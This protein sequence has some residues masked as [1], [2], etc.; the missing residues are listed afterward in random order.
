[1][2][3]KKLG[4]KHENLDQEVYRELRS[5]IFEQKLN[6]GTKIYQEKLAQ[7]FGISRTP[8]VNALKKLHQERLITAMP[9]RGF[10]VRHFSAQEIIQAFELREVLEGLAARRA[11][12]GLGRSFK[13]NLL[14]GSFYALVLWGKRRRGQ[15]LQ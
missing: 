9:R 7:E 14:F 1:L 10:Y 2:A 12:M 4:A 11:S 15:V 3:V 5:M 13:V 8:V 6:P